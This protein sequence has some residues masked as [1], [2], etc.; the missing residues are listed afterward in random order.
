MPDIKG[1]ETE[2]NLLKAF[3]GESQAR[4][5]YTYYAGIARKEG[6]R[7]IE[8]LFMETAENELQH[9]K[10]FFKFLEGGDLEITATYPAGK[11][12][13]TTIDNLKAAAAGENEEWTELYPAF[14]EKAREE[15]FPAVGV[16]FDM[17]AKVEVEHEKR[18][19]K[20]AENIENEAVFRKE[21]PA[22]WKCRNCGYVHEGDEAPAKCPACLHDRE[23][24]ELKEETY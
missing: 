13:G 17:I 4:S 19:L 23:H 7:Q 9:A 24:F 15:G 12:G 14:A 5:R 11:L 3:A 2:K 6:Y 21:E 18:F 22:R 16:A 10:R 1:T 8:A 20:L